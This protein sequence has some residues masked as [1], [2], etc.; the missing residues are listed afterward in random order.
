MMQSS[1]P[2]SGLSVAEDRILTA[3]LKE[4]SGPLHFLIEQK[5]N[6]LSASFEQRMDSC[7]KAAVDSHKSNIGNVVN[8]AVKR[9]LRGSSGSGNSGGSADAPDIEGCLNAN[10]SR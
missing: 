7:V 1:A 6:A 2:N 3:L 8:D 10:L 9:V 4:L 5:M